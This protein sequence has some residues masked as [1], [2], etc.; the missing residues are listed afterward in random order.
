MLRKSLSEIK[1][2]GPSMIKTLNQAKIYTIEELANQSPKE[3]CLIDGIGLK[4]AAKWIAEAN[5][6]LTGKEGWEVREESSFFSKNNLVTTLENLRSD[7]D[8]TIKHIEA[9]EQRLDDIEQIRLKTSKES[10]DSK[11]LLGSLPDHP[12]IRNENLLY[13]VICKKIEGITEKWLGVREVSITDLYQQIVKD[14]SIT[15][16]IFAE[17]LLMLFRKKKIQLASSLTESGFYIRDHDEQIYHIVR[18]LD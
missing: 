16:E 3:L 4:S 10:I 1:G 7:L 5:L 18:I 12:F 6:L 11:K 15:K 8:S 13:E 9:I 2:I 14:Y 17:Y